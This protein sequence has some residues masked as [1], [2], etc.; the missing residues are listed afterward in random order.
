MSAFQPDFERIF[1][2]EYG[3]VVASL[4]RRFGDLDVAEDA[5]SEAVREALERWPVEG[6]PANPGGWLTVTARNSALDKVRRESLRLGKEVAAVQIFDDTP[7]ASVGAIGDDRLRLLFTCCHPVLAEEARIALTLRLLGGLSVVEIA[8]AFFVPATTMGQR[9]T[10]AKAKIKNVGIPYQVPSSADLPERLSSVLSVLYL[11]FNEGYLPGSD[12][13]GEPVR[14]DLCEEAIRLA[15]VLH[16]LLP[17]EPEVTG[18]LA[19]MLLTD[20]RR[21]ARFAEGVLVPLADQDRSTWDQTLIA[22]GHALVR[23]CLAIN[24]PGPYQ[25]QAAI[26][27]VHTD[28]SSSEATDW[29]QVL[30]LYDQLSSFDSSPVVALNRAVAVAE[31][32]GAQPALDIVEG[33]GLEGYQPWHATRAELL[34]RLGRFAEAKEAFETAAGAS[35]N[36]AVAAYLRQQG[37]P[38]VGMEQDD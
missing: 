17:D 4:A 18:L 35:D 8:R 34:K 3:R 28:A 7:H 12:S 26:N 27:A 29:S 5:A 19:L 24:R 13:D 32:E 33:L 22:E 15:R 20:A 31:I 37:Q 10:R 36:S 25:L 23:D 2:D 1:R 30:A 16:A 38:F 9:I 14:V 11:I 6:L 21:A